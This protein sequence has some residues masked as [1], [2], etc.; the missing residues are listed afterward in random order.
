MRSTARA[1][2]LF[3][4]PGG[5]TGC[6]TFRVTYTPE[7][8]TLRFS[9][10][11]T[12][13]RACPSPEVQRQETEYLRLLEGVRRYRVSGSLLTLIL[14]DGTERTFQRPVNGG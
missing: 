6:N 10:L 7:G 11:A 5:T 4:K 3:R 14:E 1:E 2:R 13:R 9:P 8:D 12:T